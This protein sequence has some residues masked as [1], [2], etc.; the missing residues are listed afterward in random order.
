MVSTNSTSRTSPKEPGIIFF[1]G[2]CALC[3]RW[4]DFLLRVLRTRSAKSAHFPFQMASL[5]GSTAKKIFGE[6]GRSEFITPPLKTIVLY[7]RANMEEATLFLT[8]SDA[9]IRIF[10]ALEFPWSLIR[11]IRIIPRSIRDFVYR[12]VAK[13][14]YQWFGKRDTCR[15]PMPEERQFLLD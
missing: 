10:S 13:N 11:L 15:V 2:Y 8:E 14:R 3:N 6:T 1:D 7:Q 4:V 9:I 5:Q 12:V